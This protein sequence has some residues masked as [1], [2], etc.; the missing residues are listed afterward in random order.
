M[1]VGTGIK[2]LPCENSYFESVYD[3]EYVGKFTCLI[4][5]SSQECSI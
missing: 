1:N 4:F 2:F 5:G 3:V